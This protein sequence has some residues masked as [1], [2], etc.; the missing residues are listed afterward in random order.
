MARNIHVD[1]AGNIQR[2]KV[3]E[4]LEERQTL[5]REQF[6]LILGTL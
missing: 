1:N 2:N 6:V 3:I 4:I 5:K